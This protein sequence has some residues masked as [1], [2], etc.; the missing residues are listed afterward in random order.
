MQLYIHVIHMY[1]HTYR[2]IQIDRHNM[3]A[4]YL[5]ECTLCKKQYRRKAEKAS[6]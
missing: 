6:T 3:Q 4:F 1:I 5:I 2:W